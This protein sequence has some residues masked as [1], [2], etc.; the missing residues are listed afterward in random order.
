MA[1]D[2]VAYDPVAYRPVAYGSVAHGSVSYG[3]VAY[4]SVAYGSAAHGSVAYGSV[5]YVSVAENSVAYGCGGIPR[6]KLPPRLIFF[7]EAVPLGAPRPT[8][9]VSHVRPWGFSKTLNFEVFQKV[10]ALCKNLVP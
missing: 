1:S 7:A 4:G 5:T 3:S 6:Q 9:T 8:S 10:Q 2:S